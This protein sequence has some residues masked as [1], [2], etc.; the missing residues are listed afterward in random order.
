[1]MRARGA[2]QVEQA[3]GRWENGKWQDFDPRATP[4][5]VSDNPGERLPQAADRASPS[6]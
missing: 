5:L 1:V 3:E 6:H 2:K 4:H